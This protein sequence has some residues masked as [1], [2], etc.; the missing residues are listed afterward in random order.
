MPVS[1]TFEKDV[2]YLTT[3]GAATPKDTLKTIFRAFK[4][5]RY[6]P[7]ST[8]I[9]FDATMFDPEIVYTDKDRREIVSI[10]VAN[11]MARSAVIVTDPTR[12]KAGEVYKKYLA[13]FGIQQGVFCDLKRAVEWIHGGDPKECV[14]SQCDENHKCKC[15]NVLYKTTNIPARMEVRV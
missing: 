12:C 14:F 5:R 13:E 4:D 3:F 7:G 2:L 6:I 11:G 1:Y 15:E 10:M 8:G 9:I